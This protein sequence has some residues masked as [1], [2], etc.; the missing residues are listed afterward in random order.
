MTAQALACIESPCSVLIENVC[1]DVAN[2]QHTLV[3]VQDLPSVQKDVLEPTNAC[4]SGAIL[5]ITLHP[6]HQAVR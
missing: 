1:A 5:M 2:E 3:Q 6:W 4:L